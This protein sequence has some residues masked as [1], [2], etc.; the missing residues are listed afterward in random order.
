MKPKKVRR[1][2]HSHLHSYKPFIDR[3]RDFLSN[4]VGPGS[5]DVTDGMADMDI[6]DE[7]DSPESQRTKGLKYMSQFVRVIYLPSS[8]GLS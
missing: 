1:L 6:G 2:G 5:S 8:S 3:I 7:G 4:F